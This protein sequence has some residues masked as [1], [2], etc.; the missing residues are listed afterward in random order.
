MHTEA[1]IFTERRW[2]CLGRVVTSG[3]NAAVGSRSAGRALRQRGGISIIDHLAHPAVWSV[4]E[5]SLQKRPP[6]SNQKPT[7]RRAPASDRRPGPDTVGYPV[8]RH[9]APAGTRPHRASTGPTRR[10]SDASPARPRSVAGPAAAG[11]QSS[12]SS[13][14]ASRSTCRLYRPLSRG[15]SLRP[16]GSMTSTRP[17]VLASRCSPHPAGAV[18]PASLCRLPGHGAP[19][20]AG[21]ASRGHRSPRSLSRKSATS[22][23]PLLEQ[24]SRPPSFARNIGIRR[25]RWNYRLCTHPVSGRRVPDR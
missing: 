18:R 12:R 20:P 15:A 16:T 22:C 9:T 3:R 13:E 5:D 25:E 6:S 17:E 10:R 19:R 14:R 11:R 1:S 2:F 24:N 7:H 8:A 23:M 21:D 4:G